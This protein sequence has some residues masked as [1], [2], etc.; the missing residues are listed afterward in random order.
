MLLPAGYIQ[1]GRPDTGNFDAICFDANAKAS[2]REYPVVRIDHEEILCNWRVKVVQ[3][4]W[5]S[6]FA[7]VEEFISPMP[8]ERG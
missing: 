1:I 8:T 2:N 5:P 7:M 3:E 6:F 4:V